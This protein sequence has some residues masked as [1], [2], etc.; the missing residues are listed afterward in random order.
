MSTDFDTVSRVP[1]KKTDEN[2]TQQE[3]AKT[4]LIASGDTLSSI[5]KKY[6]VSTD[7][8]L[9]ANDLS[10]DDTL[11]VGTTL[12]IPPVSGV[13]HKVA[14]GDTISEISR[15]Y[16]VDADDI[17]R[18]NGL[19]NAASIRKDMELMIPGAAPR[20]AQNSNA[21]KPGEKT[22]TK[23]TPIPTPTPNTK[24][25]TVDSTTGLK[26]R[27]AIKYSGLSRGFA[28][29]NCTWYVGQYKTVTWRGNANAWMRNAKAAGA[30]T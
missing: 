26:S 27:Y 2:T 19:K 15:L 17:V 13:V 10:A 9:W 24:P 3:R 8:I 22:S 7:T 1:E 30:K 11:S 16:S 4:H 25:T 5:A 14:S 21:P 6:G 20:V 23:L 29:G 18:I 28:W 12:R